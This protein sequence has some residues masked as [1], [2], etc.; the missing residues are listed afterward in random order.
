MPE[1]VR[2]QP[3]TASGRYRPDSDADPVQVGTIESTETQI[4]F[5]RGKIPP[6]L[7]KLA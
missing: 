4:F 6:Y 2:H 5:M 1:A 3:G 7:T